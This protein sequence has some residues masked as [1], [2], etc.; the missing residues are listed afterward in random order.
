[1]LNG[2]SIKSL[3]VP[4]VEVTIARSFW[5]KRFIRLDFPTFGRPTTTSLRPSLKTCAFSYRSISSCNLAMTLLCSI[6][7]AVSIS[8]ISVTSSGKSMAAF[9]SAKISDNKSLSISTVIRISPF[10]W[11]AAI[12]S[13][14]FVLALI[15]STTASA[16]VR[17]MRP[18]IYALLVNSPGLASL[19]PFFNTS[20]RI[21][22]NT[23]CPE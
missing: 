17:S 8:K 13:A 15:M 4:G 12:S 7:V 6:L 18:F 14:L 23:T 11:V 16:C 22:L 10:T 3:V 1:M 19:A 21:E 20:S 5:S 2:S 9:I